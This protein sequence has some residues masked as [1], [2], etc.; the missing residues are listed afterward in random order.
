[1]K[2]GFFFRRLLVLKLALALLILG[3]S[4]QNFQMQNQTQSFSQIQ[5]YNNKVD[6]LL[7]MDTSSSML[8]FR[9]QLAEQI[10]S[11]ISQLN[12][13]QIDY[14]IG[15][16]TMD[17]Q[18]GGSGGKLLGSPKVLTQNTPDLVQL[19]QDRIRFVLPGSIDEMGLESMRRVLDVE[20]KSFLRSDSLLVNIFLTDEDDY[21]SD[22]K[23]FIPVSRYVED[24]DRRKPRFQSG[25]R[26]WVAHL[27][28]IDSF[29]EMLNCGAS[30]VGSRYIDLV[31]NSNGHLAPVC[32]G[33]MSQM[34]E[35]IR[36]QML[37]LLSD[38]YL[39]RR[40]ALGSIRVFVRGLEVTRS[41]SNGWDYD[42][43]TNK[44]RFFG[45]WIPGVY[46]SISVQFT[47]VDAGS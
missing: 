30:E 45:S 47:P 1:M 23:S 33:R 3:C 5:A 19:L 7:V 12:L 9:D 27:I 43:Q 21:S 25:V 31:K 16:T 42:A 38:Y 20:G 24:L 32:S 28:G 39:P 10:P 35:N 13:T 46:D 11:F 14:R 15:V 22:T 40:P 41:Q 17:L 37:Q 44:I 36:V 4:Q 26:S 34:V 6:V 18:P 29:Q 8:R 2:K